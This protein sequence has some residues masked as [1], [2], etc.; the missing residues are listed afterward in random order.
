MATSASDEQ[1]HPQVDRRLLVALVLQ[2]G[3]QKAGD[4]RFLLQDSLLM[5]GRTVAVRELG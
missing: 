3:V 5:F 4:L 2:E 1:P